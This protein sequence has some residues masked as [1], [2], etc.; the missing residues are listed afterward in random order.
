MVQ[1]VT[2][3]LHASVDIVWVFF[4]G[5]SQEVGRGKGHLARGRS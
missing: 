1:T 4:F 2:E 3:H 5:V